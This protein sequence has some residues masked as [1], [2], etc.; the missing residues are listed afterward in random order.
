MFVRV[1]FEQEWASPFGGGIR[2]SPFRIMLGPSV[3]I[4]AMTPVS[5]RAQRPGGGGLA[6]HRHRVV[7]GDGALEY[8]MTGALLESC[9]PQ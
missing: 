7:L 5:D 4:D 6:A 8:V 1:W 3:I 9:A 2:P